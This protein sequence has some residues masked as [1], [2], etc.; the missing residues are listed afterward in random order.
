MKGLVTIAV[1][2][3]NDCFY[4]VLLTHTTSGS[5]CL[6]VLLPANRMKIHGRLQSI[7][8]SVFLSVCLSVDQ[9]ACLY[10]HSL[11][12][13]NS[14]VY[15]VHYVIM[16]MMISVKDELL[17]MKMLLLMIMM[18]VVVMMILIMMIIQMPKVN[19]HSWVSLSISPA[20]F[21]TKY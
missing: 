19:H 7:S 14:T 16:K 21:R 8:L 13:C 1:V 20:P 2:F 6:V 11:S 4:F 9:S 17:I 12:L 15:S 18:M 3:R 5:C 10:S